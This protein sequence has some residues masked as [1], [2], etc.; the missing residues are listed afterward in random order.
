MPADSEMLKATEAAVAECVGVCEVNRV[1]DERI[2][3]E[4]IVSFDNGRHVLAGASFFVASYFESAKRLTPEE[5]LFAIK[6]VGPRR[7]PVSLPNVGPPK[8]AAT[9]LISAYRSGKSP[10]I[11]SLASLAGK[12][13]RNG[14]RWVS[15][16]S[17]PIA[18]SSAVTF[19]V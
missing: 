19:R 3:P 18:S 10:G 4:A 12:L 13:T 9:L 17:A 6:T 11:Q 2:L 15:D 16:F 8:Y 7:A 14:A 5:W 1:I